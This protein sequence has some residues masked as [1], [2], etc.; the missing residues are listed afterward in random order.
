M[1]KL[2]YTDSMLTLVSETTVDKNNIIYRKTVK[3][4]GHQHPFIVMGSIG[5]LE[6]LKKKDFKTFHPFI[7]EDYDLIENTNERCE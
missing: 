6:E 3:P 2:P 5:T 4:I 1:K 7:N